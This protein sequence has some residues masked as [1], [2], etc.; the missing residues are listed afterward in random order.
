MPLMLA[1]YLAHLRLSSWVR[2]LNSISMRSAGKELTKSM[3]RRAGT[4]IAPSSS[5]WAPIQQ[6]IPISRSVAESLRR[7]S[8]VANMT[9]LST[10][11]V[12]RV[13]TA[14]PTVANPLARFSCKQDTF[15]KLTLLDDHESYSRKNSGLNCQPARFAKPP[16][17]GIGRGFGR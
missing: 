13:A 8:S 3:S 2:T 15:I 5:T 14:R 12:L 1:S 9:L 10:G 4:V 16:A 6:L 11:S 7:P 17:S